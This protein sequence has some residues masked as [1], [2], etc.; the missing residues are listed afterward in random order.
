MLLLVF[1]IMARM[2]DSSVA[3]GE[4]VMVPVAVIVEMRRMLILMQMMMVVA[5]AIIAHL[6]K[7]RGAPVVRASG[8]ASG[9]Q[10]GRRSCRRHETWTGGLKHTHKHTHAYTYEHGTNMPPTRRHN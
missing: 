4:L 8:K 6:R 9:E 1:R 3:T 5:T 7:V 10:I 2:W